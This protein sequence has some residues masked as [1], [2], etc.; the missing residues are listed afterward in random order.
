MKAAI[1]HFK[2]AHRAV[3]ASTKSRKAEDVTGPNTNDLVGVA[4]PAK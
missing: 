4:L 2:N 3:L 1:V